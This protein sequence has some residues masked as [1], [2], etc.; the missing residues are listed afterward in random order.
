M[1]DLRCIADLSAADLRL[2]LDEADAVRGDPSLYADLLD[3]G[4]VALCFAKPSTGMYVAFQTAVT[5]LGGVPLTLGPGELRL[6]PG[7]AL[8]D[9]ARVRG[10]PVR[11]IVA[12]GL[13]HADLRQVAAAASVPI[14]NAL[15]DRHDPCQALAGLLT[16]RQR[17][18]VLAGHKV[19][20]VGCGSNVADSLLEATALAG[21]DVAV[22]TPYRLEPHPAVVARARALA[23]EHGSRVEVTLNPVVAVWGADA[24]VTDV[25]LSMHD[26]EQ[27][28]AARAHVLEIFRVDE[29]LMEAAKPNA[30]FLHCLPAHRGEEVTAEVIDGPRSLV[31]NQAGN[32]APVARAVLSAL[33]QRRLHGHPDGP[34]VPD[35]T[36]PLPTALADAVAKRGALPGAVTGHQPGAATY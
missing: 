31:P 7:E 23:A 33:L 4:A 8:V 36:G 10:R 3:G 19:A 25:W 20:Y 24:V 22:A 26:P 16:L 1:K 27:A 14:V 5:G 34:P 30:V 6:T 17:W 28:R 2:L 13:T 21:M 12:Y 11:A 32:L 18:G 29:R 15:S 35:D 9:G